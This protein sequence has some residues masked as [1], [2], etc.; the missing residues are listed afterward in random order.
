MSLMLGSTNSVQSCVQPFGSILRLGPPVAGIMTSAASPV[1]AEAPTKKP[2][3]VKNQVC[4]LW[5][6]P[7]ALTLW[8]ECVA[9]CTNLNLQGPPANHHREM[10]R[11]RVACSSE[12]PHPRIRLFQ[13]GLDEAFCREQHSHHKTG[14]RHHHHP[15]LGPLHLNSVSSCL[16]QHLQ[17]VL[18]KHA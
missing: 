16:V 9:R 14:S 5:Q 11:S 7:A 13:D 17:G 4:N 12:Y 18:R 3:T 2:E 1:G 15:E 6:V 10:W 8:S